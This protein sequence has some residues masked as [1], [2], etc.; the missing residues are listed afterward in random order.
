M[1][2]PDGTPAINFGS[3]IE[4]H[5]EVVL[6]WHD[7]PT[8]EDLIWEQV[9]HIYSFSGT[10]N[11]DPFFG[12]PSGHL[13]FNG[14]EV[15]RHFSCVGHRLANFIM[16]FG[17]VVLNDKAGLPTRGHN[18][19]VRTGTSQAAVPKPIWYYEDVSTD[20]K[21]AEGALPRLYD[22]G[23]AL[24]PGLDFRDIFYEMPFSET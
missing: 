2:Y 3:L 11:S 1:Y 8:S 14:M 12:Y 13:I 5:S 16:R 9:R 21:D 20:G 18:S 7:V 24:Y 23:N 19:F 6:T 4:N 15:T 10:V 22:Q 17:Y